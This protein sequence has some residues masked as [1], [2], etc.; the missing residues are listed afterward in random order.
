[1]ITSFYLSLC[2]RLVN[3]TEPV[4]DFSSLLDIG[5][6]T[7]SS[8]VKKKKNLNLSICFYQYVS[9]SHSLNYKDENYSRFGIF[10]IDSTSNMNPIKFDIFCYFPHCSTRMIVFCGL[11]SYVGYLSQ[12]IWDCKKL[13]LQIHYYIIF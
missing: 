7:H 4:F 1:M 10:F 12:N 3:S 6:K 9:S 2:R 5:I 13:F 11:K 8:H